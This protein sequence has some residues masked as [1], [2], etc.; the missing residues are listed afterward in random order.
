MGG[1]FL[2]FAKLDAFLNWFLNFKWVVKVTQSCL[3]LCDPMDYTAHGILQARILEWVAFPF[4]R[5]S[6]QTRNWAQVFLQ[7]KPKNTG[8]GSSS[9]L[10]WIFQTQELNRG[11]CHCRLILYQLSNEGKWKVKSE[12]EVAQLCPTLCDPM[13]C[14]LLG[15]SVHGIFQA[16]I[17]EW[18]AISFSRGS[19]QPRDWTWVSCILGRCFTV[20]ATREVMR[21]AFIYLTAPG[22]SCGT[23][24]F[25]FFSCSMW[26]LVP[27]PG[28]KPG[29]LCIGNT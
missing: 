27:W 1:V 26:D 6:S 18:V 8:V 13:D 20:W 28:F 21:E 15:Y 14:N 2:L 17:L 7:G 16:R 3:T 29:A 19:S 22:L 25:W 4:S 5:G 11:P 24:D 9:L 23:Q 12:S 10:Q